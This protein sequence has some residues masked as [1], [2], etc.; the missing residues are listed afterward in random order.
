MSLREVLKIQRDRKH[1][2]H[3]VFDK[4]L[5][6]VRKRI[7]HY[8][9]YGR[10]NCDYNI[11]Y[12]LY[13]LPSVNLKECGDYVEK[14]L[15]NEEFVVYRYNDTYFIIS[16]EESVVKENNKRNRERKDQKKH[17]KHM[18]NIEDKRRDNLLEFMINAKE[19]DQDQDLF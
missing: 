12:L 2:S 16:W 1:R 8:A 5:D 14:K 18:A 9:K 17:D 3:K 4:I 6:R 15:L 11:P 7:T 10:T 13:G 19:K